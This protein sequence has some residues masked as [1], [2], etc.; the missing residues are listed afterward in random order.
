MPS[1]TDKTVLAALRHLIDHGPLSRPDLG[2][3][4]GLARATTSPIVNDL[5][6]ARPGR[7]DRAP[8]PHGP[9]R[10]GRS[11][12]LDLDDE[13]YAVTGLEIGSDRVLAAVYSLRG[14]Q[15]LRI[16]RSAQADAVNPRAPAAPCRH[17]AARGPGRGGP[18][19]APSCS[20]SG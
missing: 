7:R 14:R 9:A 19:V 16:E 18:G 5:M 2:S 4:V 1:G 15:L 17:G 12:L 20:A 13:R 10:A 6:R 3:G 8:R 11:T